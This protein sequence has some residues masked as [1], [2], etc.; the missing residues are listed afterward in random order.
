MIGNVK[1]S[2]RQFFLLALFYVIGTSILIVPADLAADAK[3][4]AW[5]A[6]IV[7]ILNTLI[8]IWLFTLLGRQLGE[9]S[10]VEYT[11][12]VLGKWVGG[13]VSINFVYFGLHSA[14]TLCYYIGNFMV[15]QIMTETPIQFINATFVVI[16][17]MGIRLGLETV[18]RAAEILIPWF[19]GMYLVIVLSVLPDIE[20]GN[21][22]PIL[23]NGIQPIVKGAL[24][25]T[26]TS[27]F[28][29]IVFLM[30]YPSAIS[31]KQKASKALMH[32]AWIGGSFVVA[33]TAICILVLGPEHTARQMYPTYALAKKIQIAKFL[34]RIEALVAAMWVLSIYFKATLY[35]Y[36][37]IIGL[38]QILK[39]QSYRTLTYPIGLITMV[40]SLVLYPNTAYMK[41]A[42]TVVFIPYSMTI[43]LGIPLLLLSVAFFKRRKGSL[44]K[45]Q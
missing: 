37:S 18:A 41:W 29:V 2:V 23:E 45:G 13:F 3:Q 39:L 19:V 11:E 44:R 10:L 7:G 38:A 22:E 8:V 6:A 4:D 14:A 43:A 16:I 30:F 31:E 40:L 42:D 1:I 24:P 12:N 34:Q 27:G 32:A 15:T 26:A 33:I 28:V 20:F 36:S 9:Y 21:I 5:L 17:I 25:L 35:L